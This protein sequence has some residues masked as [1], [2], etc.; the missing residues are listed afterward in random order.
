LAAF[1]FK[2]WQLFAL[3]FGHMLFSEK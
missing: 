3:N 2:L 1:Y